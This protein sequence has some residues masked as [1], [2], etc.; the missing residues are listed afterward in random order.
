MPVTLEERQMVHE[1]LCQ[2]IEDDPRRLAV[3]ADLLVTIPLSR[4][5]QSPDLAENII[6]DVQDQSIAQMLRRFYMN[7]AITWETHYAPLLNQLLK[8]LDLDVYYLVADTTDVGQNHRALV[9]SLAYHKR[10]L[11]LIWHVE[12]GSKGHTTEEAQV[13]LIKRLYAHFQLDKPVIFLGDSEFDGVKVQRQLKLQDWYYVCRTSPNLYVY[14]EGEEDGF[15]I[16]DLAPEAGASPRQSEN[17][18]FTTKHRYGPISCF[19]C[20]E[21]PHP[22][23]LLLVYHLPPGWTPREA[24]DPRF[25]TEPLFGDCKEHG[26]RLNTSRLRHTGRLSRLFLVVAASYLWMVCLGVQV[27]SQDLADWVDRSNRRTLSIFKTGWRWFKRQ[28]KLG[29][30]VLIHLTLP[31]DFVLPALEYF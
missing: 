27:I 29:R 19:G 7:E 6:R 4:S 20:W 16:G 5:L 28:I 18:E 23:P 30:T 31:P 25:W 13:A 22:E 21:E 17:V 2:W 8:Q 24:Y 26:F 1:Q 9:L 14:P 12:L 3:F 15:P 10:S 11:P